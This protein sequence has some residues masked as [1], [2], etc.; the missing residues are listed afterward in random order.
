MKILVVDDEP[1]SRLIV[2]AALETWGHDVVEAEDIA[3]AGPGAVNVEPEFHRARVGEN[4]ERQA[5]ELK[6]LG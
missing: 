6:R 3:G 4:I 2:R 5:M 1:D